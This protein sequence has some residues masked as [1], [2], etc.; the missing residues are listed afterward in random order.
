[1]THTAEN[2]LKLPRPKAEIHAGLKFE[3]DENEY[4]KNITG[5]DPGIGQRLR[6]NAKC[7]T[8]DPR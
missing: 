8:K 5:F 6:R 7:R 2:I 4:Q 1:M 3:G